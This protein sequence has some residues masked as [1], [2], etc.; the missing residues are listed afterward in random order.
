MLDD[1]QR[2]REWLK[3]RN[4]A[5]EQVG[6]SR[7]AKE[8]QDTAWCYPDVHAMESVVQG[9]SSASMIVPHS[10]QQGIQVVVV[11]VAAAAVVVVMVK[12]Q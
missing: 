3:M 2:C 10:G 5:T 9:P 1:A 12:I 8:R 4:R 6:T 11:V 7:G